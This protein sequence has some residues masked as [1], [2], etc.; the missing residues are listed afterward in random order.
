MGMSHCL[1]CWGEGKCLCYTFLFSFYPL[2]RGPQFNL[3][4]IKPGYHLKTQAFWKL[5]DLPDFLL[6]IQST[7]SLHPRPLQIWFSVPF[8][9]P[10]ALHK[11]NMVLAI[12][13]RQDKEFQPLLSFTLAFRCPFQRCHP[14]FCPDTRTLRLVCLVCWAP[15][16]QPSILHP[17]SI[18]PFPFSSED[19]IYLLSLEKPQ[20]LFTQY[21]FSFCIYTLFCCLL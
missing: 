13:S 10:L 15:T 4:K 8:V 9:F 12:R 2:Q 6:N 1:D 19:P 17:Q 7:V 11:I 20:G 3:N 16:F 18:L 14:P 21:L 5:F